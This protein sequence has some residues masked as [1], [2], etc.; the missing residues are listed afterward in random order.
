[1]PTAC[2]AGSLW[3]TI[4]ARR[5]IFAFVKNMA[6]SGDQFWVFAHVTLWFDARGQ[7][8]GYHSNRRVPDRKMLETA[9]IPLYAKVLKDRARSRQR[10]RGGRG[11]IQGAH[12]FR[13]LPEGCLKKNLC[14][15]SKALLN[16]AAAA[17]GSL[18][19]SALHFSG[20]Q[21]ATIAVQAI[22][23]AGLGL[24]I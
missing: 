11:G 4:V 21:T 16:V 5:E 24:A 22:A 18:V 19:A 13:R 7:M 8:I 14:F 23:I 2:S 3:D 20:N 9:I 1:M 12:R 6:S 10:K 15:L 17:G